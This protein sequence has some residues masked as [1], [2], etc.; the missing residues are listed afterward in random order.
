VYKRRVGAKLLSLRSRKI[1]AKRAPANQSTQ[2]AVSFGWLVSEYIRRLGGRRIA[3]W[4]QQTWL[5]VCSNDFLGWSVGRAN[6]DIE[7]TWILAG[8]IPL[9]KRQ[10]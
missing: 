4:G 2:I 7:E 8:V 9:S 10:V 5:R 1:G 6:A 3:F